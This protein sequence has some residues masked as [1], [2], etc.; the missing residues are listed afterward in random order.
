MVRVS[1]DDKPNTLDGQRLVGNHTTR[2]YLT[3]L[4]A[5]VLQSWQ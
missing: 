1:W 4:N 5:V 3:P 2:G